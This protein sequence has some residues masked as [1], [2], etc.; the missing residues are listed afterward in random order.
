[1]VKLINGGLRW[2]FAVTLILAAVTLPGF[3]EPTGMA[4]RLRQLDNVDPSDW[5]IRNGC[6]MLSRVR[7]INFVD[8]QTAILELP[9]NKQAVLRLVRECQGI[10]RNGY[11]LINRDGRLCARFDSVAVVDSG[12][13]SIRTGMPC[14][15]ESIEPHLGL[16]HQ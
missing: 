16:E 7:S 14:Q 5:G 8:D 1:M 9:G 3:A 13:G 6:V 12:F 2:P 4:E 10:A 11:A 15:V